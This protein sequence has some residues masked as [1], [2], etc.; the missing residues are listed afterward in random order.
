MVDNSGVETLRTPVTGTSAVVADGQVLQLHAE[1]VVIAKSVRK[2]LV[3]ATRT[4]R[5]RDQAV[6]ED[7]VRESVVVD[8]VTINRVVDVVPPVREEGD[9]IIVPVVEEIVVVERRLILKEEIHL[10]RVRTTERHIET[11]ALREQEIAI[12]R[13]AIDD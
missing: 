1:A 13:T 2:T 9:V 8:R 3:R 11:V 4:T 12:T 5:S 7:L 6:E 10:R